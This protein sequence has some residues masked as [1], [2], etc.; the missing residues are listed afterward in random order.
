MG[1]KNK[2]KR[3]V[4]RKQAARQK[5]ANAG[6]ALAQLGDKTGSGENSAGSAPVVRG[7]KPQLAWAPLLN[8]LLIFLIASP[9]IVGP[10]GQH[11][12]YTPD[13]HMAA[14]IQVGGMVLLTVFLF[15]CFFCRRIVVPRSPLLLPLLIFYAWA[16][17]S[18]LWAGT[19]YEAIADALDWSGA[20]VCALLIVLLLREIRLLRLLLFFLLASGVC[21]AL[22][23]IGQYLFG[24]DWVQQHIVPAATFSNKNMAGQ[25]GVLTLPIAVAFFLNSANTGRIRLFAMVIALLMTYIFYTRARGAMVGLLTEIIV[26]GCILFYFKRKHGFH[27]FGD[28]PVKKTALALS[29]LAFIG[30]AYLTPAMFGN[31]DKVLEA[32]IGGKQE[33]L[34]AKHGGENLQYLMDYTASGNTRMTIWGNSIPMIR[35]NLLI[36]VGLG[37]WTIQYGA[38]QSWFRPDKKLQ[39][40][41]YHTNAHNDYIEI[42]CELGIIGFVLFV[43]VVVSLLKVAGRLL[44][45]YDREYCLM[46]MAL[47]TAIVGIG[48]NAVFS[49]PLKQPV[50]IFMLMTYIGVL[51]NLYGAKFGAGRELVLSLRRAP[52]RKLAV[53]AAVFVA[54]IMT[55]SLFVLQYNWYQSELHYRESVLSLQQKKYQLS[56]IE[57]KHAYELNPLRATLLWLQAAALLQIGRQDSYNTAIALLEAM[58]REHPYT[59]NMLASLATAYSEGG[60][61]EDA[62][63]TI[64]ALARLQP[65]NRRVRYRHGGLLFNADR[66]EEAITELQAARALYASEPKKRSSKNMVTKID[67]KLL[68]AEHQAEEGKVGDT[69]ENVDGS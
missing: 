54:A 38:Y 58:R 26:M 49:F 21:M 1:R 60:R 11:N 67:A 53:P 35:D 30:M 40:S 32:S 34:M 17:L 28:L 69:S 18:V 29:L 23:G 9:A 63:E 57:S 5:A 68:A 31:A 12:G 16:M 52:V 33:V 48:V 10:Y 62:A 7:S 4:A 61:H 45:N 22:F 39:Q 24:I 42:L 65:D 37:N 46:A 8:G 14:Y 50:P 41:L 27:I 13:L 15:S 36:G 25:Y 47:A 20:F 59:S 44:A 56:Y 2:K 19:K 6:G 64:G 3:Q 51:S 43:W 66:F 55:A